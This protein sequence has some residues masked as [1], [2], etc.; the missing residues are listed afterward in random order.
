MNSTRKRF[1]AGGCFYLT[2]DNLEGEPFSTARKDLEDSDQ[3]EGLLNISQDREEGTS[4]PSKKHSS[5][6]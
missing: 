1:S 3:D 6:I 2:P 5:K 4:S